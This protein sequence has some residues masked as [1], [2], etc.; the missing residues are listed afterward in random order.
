MAPPYG[1]APREERLRAGIPHP[2]GA[3]RIDRRDDLARLRAP[4]SD[5]RVI[6]GR[7]RSR[8]TIPAATGAIRFAT[9]SKRPAAR[10]VFF[11]RT[12]QISIQSRK[13]SQTS[14]RC[15]EEP[16][17]DPSTQSGKRSPASPASSR[18]RNARI[19]S[20]PLDTIT[21]S[22]KTLEAKPADVS[23]SQRGTA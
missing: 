20:P 18:R 19:S 14:R 11:R 15:Y 5:A 21:F 1:R 13:A 4:S 2:H 6:P 22:L 8:L 12:A 3:R 16:P 9:R 23:S 7:C 17:S 10:C